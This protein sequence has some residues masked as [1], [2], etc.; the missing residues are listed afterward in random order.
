MSRGST[1]GVRT[2]VRKI[3]PLLCAHPLCQW[4]CQSAAVACDKATPLRWDFINGLT[5]YF[6]HTHDDETTRVT[7]KKR[8]SFYLCLTQPPSSIHLY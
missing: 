2:A 5:L 3:D 4:S 1:Q 8:A 7:L 6:N